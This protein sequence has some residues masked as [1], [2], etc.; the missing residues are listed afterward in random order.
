[1][2]VSDFHKDLKNFPKDINIAIRIGNDLFKI[3]IKQSLLVNNDGVG[4]EYVQLIAGEKIL[5]K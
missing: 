3:E 2:N 5:L 1:M 4:Y